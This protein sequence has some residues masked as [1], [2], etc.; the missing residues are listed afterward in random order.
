[1]T[2]PE[3]RRG[4]SSL[5]SQGA[6]PARFRS[7]WRAALETVGALPLSADEL[8]RLVGELCGTVWDQLFDTEPPR[9]SSLEVGRQVGAQLVEAHLTD[10]HHLELTVE[11]LTGPL[12]ELLDELVERSEGAAARVAGRR[13]RGRLPQLAAGVS[14]GFGAAL[15]DL[16][17]RQQEETRTAVLSARDQ[18]ESALRQSEARFRAVFTDAAVGIGIGDVEGRIIEV[19]PALVELF[20]YTAEEFS[21]RNVGEFMHPQDAA[22]IW[23]DY[24]A[25]MEG[26]LESFRGEK[27]FYRSDGVALW[28]NLTVSL[29]RSEDGRPNYQVAI[30]QDV[31]AHH[32]LRQRLRHQATHD[33]LTGLPNRAML[34]QRLGSALADPL[35]EARVGLCFLDLDSFK[36]VNDSLG[37]SVG[38]QLLAAV[39]DRFRAPAEACGALLARVGGDEFVVLLENTTGPQDA[40][41]CAHR[42]SAALDRPIRV[43]GHRFTVSTSVGVVEQPAAD[44]SPAELMR[45]ADISLHWAKSEGKGRAVVHDPTRNAR[46]VTRYT[47]ANSLPGALDRGEFALAYQP[48]IRL[49][50]GAV[51]GTEALLRWNH[52]QFGVLG[53][54]QFVTIAEETGAILTLGRWVL[55]EACRQAA[56]WQSRWP[57]DAVMSVNIA[58]RQLQEDDIAR[59]VERTLESTGLPPERL[60]LE[61][62]ETAIMNPE[63]TGP[64]TALR[65]LARM[66]VRIAIDDFGTGYANL[67]AL[68]RMPLHELK[69]AGTFLAGMRSST[70][71]DPVDVE[72][73]AT[74]VRMAHVMGLAVVAE[75]VETA[76]QDEWM[77][78]IGCDYGQGWFY[79]RP[80]DAG[81]VD[82]T[83][84]D[85]P[86]T[87]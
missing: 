38:D 43:G 4:P 6:V 31:T 78:E 87:S 64:L 22:S 21:R 7:R 60:Q 52:P 2:H 65:R 11:L 24:Q 86:R 41:E 70:S 37:H 56:A 47:L 79:A 66:G 34:L 8:D 42:L 62:T 85:P 67:A 84:M 72:I 5:P 13:A 55:E 80:T 33:D 14:G 16:V 61:V 20:G 54:D 46:Q 57:G 28:T 83:A 30:I 81:S 48:L 19:N 74:L 12:T 82:L 76:G 68:R 51:H 58:V 45:A 25:L 73:V 1:M 63:I 50:D 40:L 10:V 29:I 32:Q 77:R 71:P 26:R 36:M 53:P 69:L 17:L 39:A 9:R 23:E 49:S 27:R 15:Q 18:A 44:T 75:G 35:P 59:Q 3:T